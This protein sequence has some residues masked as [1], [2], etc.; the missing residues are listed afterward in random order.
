MPKKRQDG[1]YIFKDHPEFTPNLSPNDVIEQG[2]FGGTYYR[3]IFS[4]VT[5]Q[6]YKDQ[7]MEFK[8]SKKVT[9]EKL[10]Q[11]TCEQSLNKF[12]VKSGTSL[13][14]WE[15]KGWIKPQD[16]YGWFQWY[17][18]FFNGRRSPDDERQIKRWLGICGPKGRFRNRLVNMIKNKKTT[19]HDYTVS[20][21]IRQL[22]HQWGYELRSLD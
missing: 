15:E 5:K 18:R 3:P 13:V 21:V 20:P 19:V 2:A 7:W 1:T 6:N 14:F 22:L 11:T 10:Y 17:C 4:G 8:W 9:P 12:K 16:P